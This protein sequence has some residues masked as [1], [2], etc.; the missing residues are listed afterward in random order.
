[1][2]RII[3]LYYIILR[4]ITLHHIKLRKLLVECPGIGFCLQLSGVLCSQRLILALRDV[5]VLL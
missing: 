2:Y 3:T 4:Y 5:T 1:M